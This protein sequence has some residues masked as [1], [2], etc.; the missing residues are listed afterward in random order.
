MRYSQYKKQLFLSMLTLS[1]GMST[2]PNVLWA[3]GEVALLDFKIRKPETVDIVKNG[4]QG[5]VFVF[6]NPK[7][8]QLTTIK[9]NYTQASAVFELNKDL[10]RS[11]YLTST[12]DQVC[13]T[14]YFFNAKSNSIQA[15]RIDLA[16]GTTQTTLCGTIP[17]EESFLTALVIDHTFYMFTVSKV[18][19]TL[20]LW[21]SF[22][23]ASL[24]KTAFEIGQETLHRTLELRGEEL[25]EKKY[26]EIGIDKIDYSLENNLKSAHALNKLYCLED[27]MVMTIDDADK[28]WLYIIDPKRKTLA[29]KKF[30]FSLEKGEG[31]RDKQGNSFL[32]GSKLF[33]TT[34]NNEMMNVSMVDID[35]AILN[36]S[37]NIFPEQNITIK[38]GPLLAEGENNKVLGK[39]SQY[40]NRVL[41]GKICIAVNEIN[42]QY[43]LQVGSYEY[44]S[45]WGSPAGSPSMSIGMG[46]GMSM[47]G[48]GMG[49]YPMGGYGWGMPGYYGGYP[50]YYPSG[51]FSSIETTYFYSLMDVKTLEHLPLAPPKTMKERLND[52]EDQ[53]FKKGMPDLIQVIALP[54][55]SILM[56][57]Y[58]RNIHKYQLVEIR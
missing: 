29:E 20:A 17:K 43:L 56:G 30:S 23:G 1:I 4:N 45:S 28:T 25:N 7:Q 39:T 22:R 34:I 10:S 15:Y 8:I 12:R 49:Y 36:W 58:V 54:N 11:D 33:R 44:K 31:S 21:S 13:H 18:S 35:S 5:H 26:S 57:Y 52:F 19:S 3:Q 41:N 50:G 55:K 48:V 32:Y 47:G 38:N 37:Y 42:Q 2:V 6:L 14:F 9:P 16:M 27:R 46:M 51:N 40:F 53:K 24:E